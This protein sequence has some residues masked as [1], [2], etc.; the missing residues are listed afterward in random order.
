MSELEEPQ[1]GMSDRDIAQATLV[2]LLQIRDMIALQIRHDMPEHASAMLKAHE[3]GG[4]MLDL[5]YYKG[6]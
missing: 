1:E 4:L 5:P 2:T 6:E 3:A